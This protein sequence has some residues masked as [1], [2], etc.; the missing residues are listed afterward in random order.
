MRQAYGIALFMIIALFLVGRLIVVHQLVFF[1]TGPS[2][3]HYRW[4][5]SWSNTS[6]GTGDGHN[7]LPESWSNTSKGTGDGHNTLPES[8]SN[9]SK[10]FTVDC[11]SGS[12]NTKHWPQ[13]RHIIS[14]DFTPNSS[15]GIH[16][17]AIKRQS[18]FVEIFHKRQWG[19]IKSNPE[20][21]SASGLGSSLAITSLVRQTLDCVI[22]DIKYALNKKV[23]RLLDIPCGDLRWMS[24]FL[25][26]RTDIEYTGMD[27]VPDIIEHHTKTYS[28][29]PWT[30]RV[31]DIVAEPLTTSYDLIF[32]RDMTQHLTIGDTLRVLKHFSVSG[33]HFAMMTTYPS[34]LHNEQDLD[35][36]RPGRYYEQDLERPPYSLTSTICVR[37]G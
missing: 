25:S 20:E 6:K 5:E 8:W 31:H 2:E 23:L 36:D 1:G 18:S 32:S 24:V 30:F 7:T 13:Q 26:N 17:D 19:E 15:L 21:L 3:V 22:N 10:G 33:S 16:E 28:D 11:C 4:P 34:R 35:V 27:I 14:D 9:T 12:P 37:P 29:Q